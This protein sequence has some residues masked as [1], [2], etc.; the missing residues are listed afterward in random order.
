MIW[1]L[2]PQMPR[3]NRNPSHRRPK[4][5][6]PHIGCEKF[7]PPQGRSGGCM[8]RHSS[9]LPALFDIGAYEHNEDLARAALRD[10]ALREAFRNAVWE[11][12]AREHFRETVRR[13]RDIKKTGR[14]VA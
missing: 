13:N 6:F 9:T 2:C 4:R 12:E 10:R 14:V 5:I 7:R 1:T 11:T 8:N 3:Q